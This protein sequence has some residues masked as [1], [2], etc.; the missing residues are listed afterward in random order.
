MG[1]RTGKAADKGSF[2]QT[3]SLPVQKEIEAYDRPSLEYA[4]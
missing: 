3:M 4:F 2:R 1:N